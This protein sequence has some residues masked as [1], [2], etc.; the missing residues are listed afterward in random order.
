M[1][2]RLVAESFDELES[3]PQ[4]VSRSEEEGGDK[5]NTPVYWFDGYFLID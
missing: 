4:A 1:P 2:Q 3:Q 5:D